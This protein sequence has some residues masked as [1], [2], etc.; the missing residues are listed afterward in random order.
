MLRSGPIL[1]HC[2]A[3]VSIVS[4]PPNE[5]SRQQSRG[6]LFLDSGG[7]LPKFPCFF[8]RPSPGCLP[9]SWHSI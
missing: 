3:M 6:C 2:L 4:K 9:A 5:T 1:G 8:P 7:F